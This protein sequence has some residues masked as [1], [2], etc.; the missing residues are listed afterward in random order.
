MKTTTRPKAG[1]RLVPVI[2]TVCSLV[3]ATST[4]AGTVMVLSSAN[5]PQD[6]KILTVLAAAGHTVTLGP[7]AQLFDSGVSLVGIQAVVLQMNYN[8]SSGDMQGSGQTHLLSF[9]NS[10]GGL[11]TTEWTLW[12]T[13]W[14]G[15]FSTLEAAFPVVPTTA[16]RGDT[17]V[18][19]SILTPDPV[20]DAGVPSSFA[21]T[22]DSIGGT[23]T[24]F[25]PRVGATRFFDSDYGDGVIGW[26]YGAGRVISFS[27][28]VGITS[29]NDANYAR[30]VGN[31]AT[32]ATVP[33][34]QNF[35]LVLG[36]GCMAL[37][38]ERR[39]RVA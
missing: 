17:T 12:D 3:A 26:Q 18:T 8:G 22:A 28:L 11:M 31:A 38:L 23:E 32:W 16:W 24:Y 34:A 37:A 36:L 35:A 33:E 5:A 29:L 13:G 19:Y 39:T 9:V 2:A 14:S 25:S 15:Q 20:L 7:T 30:L 21:F 27:T 6:L 10:G 4:Q 1:R